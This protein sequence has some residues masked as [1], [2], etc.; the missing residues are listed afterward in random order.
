VV[1]VPGHGN[2]SRAAA[3]SGPPGIF[4]AQKAATKTADPIHANSNE[5]PKG[6]GE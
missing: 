2:E 1:L 3:A 4:P 6:S 5:V